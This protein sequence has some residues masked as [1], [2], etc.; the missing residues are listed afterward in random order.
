[1][2]LASRC[3][4]V[5]TLEWQPLNYFAAHCQS[6]FNQLSVSNFSNKSVI[7][8]CTLFQ[9]TVVLLCRKVSGSLWSF[10]NGP[11]LQYSNNTVKHGSTNGAMFLPHHTATV[12]SNDIPWQQYFSNIPWCRFSNRLLRTTPKKAR[13]VHRGVRLTCF[14]GAS[15]VNVLIVKK[16]GPILY[17]FTLSL[18]IWNA[19]F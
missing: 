3:W 9:K 8:L 12:H 7:Y 6:S 14:N 17:S 2:L 15:I 10:I 16:R 4:G 11:V 19:L 1:M 13:E 5:T 18:F